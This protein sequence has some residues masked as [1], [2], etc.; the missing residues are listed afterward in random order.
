MIRGSVNGGTDAPGAAETA[1]RL[2]EAASLARL[3]GALEAGA[4]WFLLFQVAALI[5][6]LLSGRL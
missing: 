2:H 5:G 4:S 6:V 3:A 1:R